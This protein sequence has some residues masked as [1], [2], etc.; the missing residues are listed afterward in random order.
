MVGVAIPAL[1]KDYRGE[2]KEEL[3]ESVISDIK[4]KYSDVYQAD[5]DLIKQYYKEENYSELNNL[6][7]KKFIDSLKNF[8]GE[9]SNVTITNKEQADLYFPQKPKMFLGKKK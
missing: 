3:G 6:E 4:G 2:L 8:N 7:S 5:E 1:Y 9:E